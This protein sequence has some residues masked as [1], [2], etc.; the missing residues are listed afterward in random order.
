MILKSE[1]YFLIFLFLFALCIRLA[2]VL[3]L[4]PSQLS[5]D[6]GEWIGIGESIASGHGVGDAWRP[7]GYPAV[8]AGIFVVFGKSVVAV[9]IFNSIIGA[10]TCLI[11]FFIG[12]KL[13]NSQVGKIAGV[14]LSFY[15][16][17]INYTGDL[18]SETF[19][20][21]I[22]SLSILTIFIAKEKPCVLNFVACGS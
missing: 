7:P 15:P 9:R 19:F 11:I 21:F 6:T 4:S 13:F 17:L 2:Y 12:K 20:T 1:K 10:L 5:T 18:L 22:L 14:L 8:L 16:Y 3:P